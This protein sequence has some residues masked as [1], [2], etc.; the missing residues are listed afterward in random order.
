MLCKQLSIK[1]FVA[2]RAQALLLVFDTLSTVKQHEKL[3]LVG[4]MVDDEVCA[5]V[6]V[7][8]DSGSLLP[9]SRADCPTS[10]AQPC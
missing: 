3:S 9:S 10:A 5:R 7:S 6:R 8:T 2:S 1:Q 4:E